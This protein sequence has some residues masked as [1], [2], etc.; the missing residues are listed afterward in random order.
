MDKKQIEK[1]YAKLEEGKY[2]EII[3]EI[4]EMADKSDGEL[5]SELLKILGLTYFRQ[6]SYKLSQNVF[7]K[8]TKNSNN[9]NDW[10]NLLTA[11]TMNKNI[12]LSE[13]VLK[14]TLYLYQ[15]NADESSVP[16][17]YIYFYYMQA[18]KDVKEYEK[19]FKQLENLKKIYSKLVITDGTFLY[20]RGVPFF[21]ST[22]DASK[23]ILENIEKDRVKKFIDEL[24]KKVDEEGRQYLEEFERKIGYRL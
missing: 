6:E 17:A 13:K 21:E 1:L 8:Q 12:Y 4:K 14:K 9:P 23:E 10:L 18:L 15:K 22:L 11:S 3:A 2:Q 19:A 16:I 20:L 24:R 7:I 5:D